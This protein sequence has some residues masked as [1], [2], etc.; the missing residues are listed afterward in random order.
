[1]RFRPWLIP[2][3]LL[4]LGVA[5]PALAQDDKPNP[6]PFAA[7]TSFD[8]RRMI[9]ELQDRLVEPASSPRHWIDIGVAIPV[10]SFADRPFEPGMLLRWSERV[11]QEGP[12]SLVGSA[13][14]LFNDDSRFNETSID[15]SYAGGFDSF[16]PINSHRHLA[17]PFAVELHLEPASEE[18]WSPFVALGPAVQYTHEVL[19][20]Q[21]WT[22][23]TLVDAT[24]LAVPVEEGAP[25]VPLLD[26][27]LTKTH[28]HPGAQGRAGIRFK[29]GHGVSPLHIR[30]TGSGNVWYEHSHPQT[31]AGASLSFGR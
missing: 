26:Q 13:G 11:W 12:F 25:P 20:R 8:Q 18:A 15:A 10:G 23:I 7:G 2:A 1:M 14:V 24:I 27:V 19:G 9:S 5:S 16:L 6:N 21:Q 3:A 29:V 17:V 30:L 28:F 4:V 22:S 31:I